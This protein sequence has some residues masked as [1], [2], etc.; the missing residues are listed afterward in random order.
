MRRVHNRRASNEHFNLV[1]VFFDDQVR[2]APW[3]ACR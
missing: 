2:W 3:R 1:K